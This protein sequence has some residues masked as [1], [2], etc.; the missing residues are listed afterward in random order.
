MSLRCYV[1]TNIDAL[2]CSDLDGLTSK[3]VVYQIPCEE[4]LTKYS[5]LSG[6][7]RLKLK[8]NIVI[9]H[10]RGCFKA[11]KDEVIGAICREGYRVFFLV[12]PGHKINRGDTIGF[13][14][15][16]KRVARKIVSNTVGEVIAIIQSPFI[17]P[18]RVCAIIGPWRDEAL[19]EQP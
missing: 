19:G 12:K 13:L 5:E 9:A 10:E 6:E 14:Y 17:K 11:K 18:E 7:S 2:S 8:E 4:I 16:N 1:V 3:N 15:S